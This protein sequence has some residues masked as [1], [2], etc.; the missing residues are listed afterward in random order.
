MKFHDY[1]KLINKRPVTWAKEK[2]LDPATIWRVAT[3]KTF[4]NPETVRSIQTASEEAVKP[5]DWY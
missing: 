5:E 2:G 3:G 4:P 1:L